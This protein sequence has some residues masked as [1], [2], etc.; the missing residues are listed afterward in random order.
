[1]PNIEVF[2][3]HIIE[4]GVL[5]PE[6]THHEFKSGMHGQK[7]DFDVIPDD[8][9]LYR[10]WVD[11][12]ADYIAF[13]LTEFPEII[14]GV[15][16]GTNRLA[17]DV[18]RRFSDLTIGLVTEKD[19]K[20]KNRILLTELGRRAIKGIQPD[21]I[22]VL[23]DVGTTGSS[24]VQPAVSARELLNNKTDQSVTV[25]TTWKRRPTLEKLDE[26]GIPHQ[27]IID[28]P[29]TTY[30]PEDCRDLEQGFCYRGWEF[31]PR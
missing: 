21:H 2:R 22:L 4:A 29:L 17:L 15:A 26:Q 1:M 23:E 31:I 3:D 7:L 13:E 25:L 18:A 5:D 20:D 14:L 8:S 11:V 16:N 9:D 19:P 6:G 12:T 10:E 30:S 27:A 28:E 24:S